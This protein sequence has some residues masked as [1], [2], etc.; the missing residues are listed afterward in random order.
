MPKTE[1]IALSY[2]VPT[3]PS[4]IRVFVWR[5]LRSIG[6][7]AL[8]P[9][10]AVLP[11]C[12][13]GLSAFGEL[14]KK[15]REFGGDATIIEM[16]FTDPDENSDMHLRFSQA[17]EQSLKLALSECDGL[18]SQLEQAKDQRSRT[19]IERE[20]QRRLR[21]IKNPVASAPSPAEEIE[22]AAGDIFVALKGL[23]AELASLLRSSRQTK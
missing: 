8:R 21:R 17:R 12:H 3:S 6:A 10:M 19:A 20:L 14:A 22:Q 13:E 23:N 16:N 7:Q 15:I 1:W 5:R 2:S 18:I 9:G 11:N 4:K